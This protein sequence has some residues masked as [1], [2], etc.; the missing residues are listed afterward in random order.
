MRFQKAK[1][2]FFA[3]LFTLSS[4]SEEKVSNSKNPLLQ[5]PDCPFLVLIENPKNKS[6]KNLGFCMYTH[7]ETRGIFAASACVG[8]LVEP[9]TQ[10]KNAFYGSR[11]HWGIEGKC[12]TQMIKEKFQSKDIF[13]TVNPI[14]DIKQKR[15][16]GMKIKKL[17]DEFDIWN[18][19][20][21][22][23]RPQ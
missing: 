18:L 6:A 23:T 10:S 3:L 20:E 22:Q 12:N 4:W 7:T 21:K 11:G 2:I 13:T 8:V 5:I 16:D 17:R 19:F 1:F 9:D 15:K 14:T